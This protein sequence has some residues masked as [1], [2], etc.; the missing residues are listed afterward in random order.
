M[1]PVNDEALCNADD[2]V[3]LLQAGDM[4]VLDRVT[5]CF[6]QRLSREG[7]RRCRTSQDAEDAVQ[8]ATL[9][10]WRFGPGYR[11]EGSLDRW[12]VRLVATACTRMRR[13][14]KRDANLHV[15]D[16]DLLSEADSPEVLAARNRLAETL[17]RS[18]DTLA[19]RDRAIVLLADGEGMTGPE[20]AQALSMTPGAVR[21]RLSRAHSRL[22]EALSEQGLGAA[23]SEL[24]P[25]RG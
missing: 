1:R 18:L 12:L 3:H 14:K 22:R 15:S 5:R 16:E 4:A 9:A 2:L 25:G 19:P 13:G 17:G 11:A 7:Q 23:E 20:I 21:T 6:G 24:S 10:A 8:E